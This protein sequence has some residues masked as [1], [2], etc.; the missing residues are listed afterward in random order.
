MRNR[1]ARH[2]PIAAALSGLT[3]N[4]ATRLLVEREVTLDWPAD[5]ERGRCGPALVRT[6]AN[7]V[8]RFCPQIRLRRHSSFAGEIADLIR[9]IDRAADPFE[10]AGPDPIVVYLGGFEP[11]TPAAVTGSSDGW[12]AHVS[13]FGESLPPL[14]E[15]PNVL[16]AHA[17]AAL[18]ASQVFALALRL[19]R[20]V[21]GPTRASAFSVFDY[22][23]GST[24]APKLEPVALGGPALLAGVGAVGQACVDV[25][26]SGGVRGEL[27]AVD[28]GAVDDASNLN[29]S[30]L[31][32]E[33]DLE[34][35]TPKV[36]LAVRRAH[37]S[38]LRVVPHAVPIDRVVA[39]IERH[40]LE[41]PA[42]ALSALDN[43][44]ARLELQA[45]WPEIILEGS[46]GDTLAQV[47]RHRRG[48]PTACLQCLHM[49]SPTAA[50]SEGTFQPTVSFAVYLAG[51]F[52]A[53]ELLKAGA[54]I[55]SVLS[56]C[57]QMDPLATLQP[58]GPFIQQPLAECPCASRM[59]GDGE[60]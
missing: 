13:G 8:V 38:D 60:A 31:A 59:R 9:S 24:S 33:S 12:T 40:D 37:G 6:T 55:P 44:E 21:G 58:L 53:A 15:G 36:E 48:E 29:R 23:S 27:Q 42:I 41:R 10:P 49:G 34:K 43:R 46:T 1:D 28:P 32:M 30:A 57:Y 2:T 20:G 7:L 52:L 35:R 14:A 5:L 39:M 51:V 16:G 4:D 45:L 18:V 25:L 3:Q 50:E 22:G 19:D 54:G 17:A 11:A 47:F 26:V 56:G